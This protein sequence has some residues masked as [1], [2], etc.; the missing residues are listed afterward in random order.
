MMTLRCGII[1]SLPWMSSGLIR[2]KRI[3]QIDNKEKYTFGLSGQGAK[4]DKK[5]KWDTEY[6]VFPFP[7]V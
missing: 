4:G 5:L 7:L 3:L 1:G 2:W 6:K